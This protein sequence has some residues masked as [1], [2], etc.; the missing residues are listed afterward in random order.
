MKYEFI[1]KYKLSHKYLA[2]IFGYKNVDSFRCG[3]K[4][5]II[6]SAINEILSKADEK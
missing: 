2:R 1:K 5:K 6:M 4:H 3:S